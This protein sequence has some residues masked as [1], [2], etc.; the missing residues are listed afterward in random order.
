[1]GR[2]KGLLGSGLLDLD[3]DSKKRSHISKADVRK[4]WE[5][6][7]GRCARCKKKLNVHAYHIDHKVPKALG[8]SDS[9]RNLQL[10][11]PECHMLKTQEDRKK[12]SKAKKK[13]DKWIDSLLNDSIFKRSKK[14]LF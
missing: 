13:Q 7:K 12:I 1:M 4:L 8:G 5:K 2:R 14:S 11:C 6:Q 10:L 9:I 3:K